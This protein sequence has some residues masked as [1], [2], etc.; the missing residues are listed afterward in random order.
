MARTQSSRGGGGRSRSSSTSSTS[1]S[2][3]N[4]DGSFLGALKD[5]P[6]A[7][8]GVAA[9]VAGVAAASAFLWSKRSQIGE[10]I[11]S[12]MEKL[13]QLKAE[14]W[15]GEENRDQSDIAEEAMTLKETGRK[16]KGSRGP[17]AQQDIKAGIAES[18]QEAKAGAKAYS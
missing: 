3:T 14:R 6:Y 11:D 2:R 18:N 7:A 12:G 4:N 1:N 10:A 15:D 17:I 8:A 9:G 5:R 16:S 13:E